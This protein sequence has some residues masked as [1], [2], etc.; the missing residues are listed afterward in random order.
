M[1]KNYTPLIIL[2]L[3]LAKL[4][5]AQPPPQVYTTPFGADSIGGQNIRM[6][7]YYLIGSNLADIEK[8]V[9]ERREKDPTNQHYMGRT[10]TKVFWNWEGYGKAEC[11]LNSLSLRY[12]ITIQFPRWEMPENINQVEKDKWLAFI[13][14]LAKHELGHV[15]VDLEQFPLMEKRI[16]SATCT[17]A[18]AH[19]QAA[20]EELDQAQFRYDDATY[21][22]WLQG[23]KL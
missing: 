16:R 9:K 1:Y 10:R 13:T 18:D 17:T 4:G 19:A 8:Q 3:F 23:A 15:T 11:N 2:C 5:V 21:H 6:D 22:G 14:G 7:Y 12:E 20:M